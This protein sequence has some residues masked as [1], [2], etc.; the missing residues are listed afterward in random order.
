MSAFL[1]SPL[2]GPASLVIGVLFT[3][4]VAWWFTRARTH[5][6][7][8]MPL[9]TPLLN[10]SPAVRERLILLVDQVPLD[11]PHHIEVELISR[12]PRDITRDDF[13]QEAI[14]FDVG[15]AVIDVIGQPR[16]A[17]T[18][19]QA[20]RVTY[21]GNTI[22]VEKCLISRRE[23][24]SVSLLVDG[25]NP[26][27]TRKSAHLANVY[28]DPFTENPPPMGPWRKAARWVGGIAI[29][30]NVLGAVIATFVPEIAG[31]GSPLVRVGAALIVGWLGLA[32]LAAV[33]R[34][35][36]ERIPT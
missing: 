10:V 22:S 28:V 24:I 20:P 31:R 5:L 17:P 18:S 36:L 15:A 11:H 1:T 4:F 27:L 9:V 7:Y 30:Y 2:W 26:Q 8:G 6:Y 13:Q 16:V 19:A 34:R 3:I 21:S 29:G 33:L 32:A 25:A 23:R 12:G 14:S 35:T